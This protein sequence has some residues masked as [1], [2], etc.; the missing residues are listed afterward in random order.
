[1]PFEELILSQPEAIGKALDPPQQQ[2][3]LEGHHK[4]HPS[5]HRDQQS[6]S[7][8]PLH[9]RVCEQISQ[10]S[11]AGRSASDSGVKA[12]KLDR[13]SSSSSSR[14]GC[15]PNIS[16]A[17]TQQE[18]SNFQQQQQGRLQQQ[19]QQQQERPQQQQQQSEQQQPQQQQQRPQQQ[20]QQRLLVLLDV[21]QPDLDLPA[22]QQQLQQLPVD[23]LV[24]TMYRWAEQSRQYSQGQMQA[25]AAAATVAHAALQR[26]ALSRQQVADVAW[27]L[28]HFDVGWR[29]R[30]GGEKALTDTEQQ[31][32]QERQSGSGIEGGYLHTFAQAD[33]QLH[34]THQQQQQQLEE[35]VEQQERQQRRPGVRIE[36]GL[37]HTF[38][39]T[40]NHHHKQEQQQLDVGR[41]QNKQQQQH[42]GIPQQLQKL[43]QALP[44]TQQQQQDEDDAYSDTPCASV[45]SYAAVFQA[46]M[47][48]PFQVLPNVLREELCSMEELLEEVELRQEYIYLDNGARRVAEARLTGWQSDEGA[49][50]CYSG[51]EMEPQGSRMTPLVGKVRRGGG[52]TN[53]YFKVPLVKA[54]ELTPFSTSS[55]QLCH[56]SS[57][58][59]YPEQAFHANECRVHEYATF[60]GSAQ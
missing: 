32:Q 50:F 18:R 30:L 4:R 31:Q 19:Q 13:P 46:A 34:H 6:T 57:L 35:G 26:G 60:F 44:P 12:P 56:Q 43:F 55:N 52:V 58:H 25:V 14:N 59:S 20:Q 21:L 28:V 41:E 49:S 53:C 5:L 24:D 47:D 33:A 39:Q 3:Q 38:A 42:K 40:G 36:E 29:E 23:V 9:T 54:S 27:A 16:T 45:S 11:H 8:A 17:A 51:K 2:Q 7:Q 48:V 10:S 22:L 15:T 37:P 1:M